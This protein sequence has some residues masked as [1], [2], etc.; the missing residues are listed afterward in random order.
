MAG[1]FKH[2]TNED[3]TYRGPDLLENMSDMG[4]AVEQMFFMIGYLARWDRR[5]INEASDAYYE[6]YRKEVAWPPRMKDYMERMD[7]T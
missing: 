1:S 7:R 3:G 5:K 6:R 4:Q 2:L